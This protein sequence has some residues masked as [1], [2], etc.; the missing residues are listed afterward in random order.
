MLFY[1]NLRRCVTTCFIGIVPPWWIFPCTFCSW[2][3]WSWNLCEEYVIPASK[4]GPLGKVKSLDWKV[5]VRHFRQ[6]TSI[7]FSIKEMLNSCKRPRLHQETI[8]I[9]NFTRNKPN[10]YFRS[11]PKS[12]FLLVNFFVVDIS[13]E[14]FVPK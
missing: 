14:L 5:I 2:L 11:F 6:S 13:I 9:N 8:E 1:H 10:V 7:E 4:Q 12:F 3:I